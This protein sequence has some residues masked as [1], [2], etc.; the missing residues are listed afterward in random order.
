LNQYV[1]DFIQWAPLFWHGVLVTIQISITAMFLSMVLGLLIAL[2]RITEGGGPAHLL[3]LVLRG[4]VEVLRGLPLI[5]TLFLIYFGLPVVGI[6]I[7]DPL[8]AGVLGLT[9]ALG[10]YLSEVFRA[11]ILAIDKGQME[12]SLAFGMSR[13]AAYRHI[14]LPQALVV[15]VPTLGGYFIGLLK[16]SSLLSFIS[17]TELMSTGNELVSITFRAFEIYLMI[18]A[19]YL[20]L[21]FVAAWFVAIVE[22]RLRP[23]ER[24]FQGG[25]GTGLSVGPAAPDFAEAPAG[26]GF[27]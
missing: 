11:A 22:K 14:V 13:Y 1:Q 9:L 23:L 15:A 5:V 6:R 10:A 21:S 20:V 19:I 3:R 27:D 24:A 4:Y 12:A 26:G 18:G 17:V 8:I 2:G 25:R 16:D 7:S